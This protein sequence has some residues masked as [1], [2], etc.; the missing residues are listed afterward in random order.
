MPI[1][2]EVDAG[3]RRVHVTVTGIV[4]L[5]DVL[6]TVNGVLAVPEFGPHF[7]VLS[8]H[9]GVERPVAVRD[10]EDMLDEARAWLDAGE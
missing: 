6:D 4:T 1:R 3:A 9:R 10:V 5:R 8:D 2:F 7:R